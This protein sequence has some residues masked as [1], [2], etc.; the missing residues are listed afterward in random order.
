MKTIAF[1]VMGSD[2]GLIPAVDA[3][4]K[5]LSERK[6]LKIIFVGDE[7]QLKAKLATKKYD[8]NRVE[9]IN[10]TQVI[11]M[12]DGIMDIRRKKDSSM[13]KA[14]ELVRDGQADAITTGG[15]T[16]PFI[17]GCQFILKPLDGISKTA[18]MPVIPTINANR[19]TMLLDVGANIEIKG[20]DLEKYAIMASAYAKAVLGV[21]R[22]EV[23][24]LNIGEEKSKGLDFHREAYQ[25]MAN[26]K[27]LSFVGNIE[28]RYITNGLVDIII[29]DGYG[30]N[31]ALKS[32]EG[33]G[34]NLLSEI[35][36]AL[37]KNIWRKIAALSLRKAFKEVANKF[38]YKNYAG[39]I[40]LGV[41]KIAFKSHGSSDTQSFFATLR[42]TY[43]AITNDVITKMKSAIGD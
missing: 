16:A 43:E 28:S 8:K 27:N 21:D 23:A 38:D 36:A 14:L 26:N 19:Q 42:M 11:E 29:S 41:S 34:K 25:L 18:F 40:L 32:F 5:L 7:E 20:E 6:D 1:D 22:P 37:T 39:A 24:L 30:G 15:A 9:V 10:T 12:T 3:A 13:V 4:I 17:A 33:M 35:K 2:N 31:L